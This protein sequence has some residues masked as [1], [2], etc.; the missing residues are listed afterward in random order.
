VSLLT[1]LG[2]K[3]ALAALGAA[4]GIA[5]MS[6]ATVVVLATR[7]KPEPT[8]PAPKAPEHKKAM[9]PAP[10]VEALTESP[11]I[12]TPP[13]PSAPE[14]TKTPVPTAS[15]PDSAASAG[16]LAEETEFLER[17]RRTLKTDPE[18]ALLLVRE[19]GV[20]FPRGKLG[21][22]RSLIEIE[23]LYRS[24]HHAEARALAERKLASG[25]NDLY[26]ERIRA[27]LSRIDQGR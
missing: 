26:A 21:A 8:A 18:F 13:A 12:P 17:A 22:E 20:R 5:T 3:T 6:V 23:A 2:A 10:P 1:W 9:R 25:A 11:E 19:H 15:F 4:A 14:P 7:E 24:G 27:L 16:G